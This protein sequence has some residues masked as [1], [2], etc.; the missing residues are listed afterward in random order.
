MLHRGEYLAKRIRNLS[1]GGYLPVEV[2][3]VDIY[4]KGIHW[5]IGL[6]GADLHVNS[7]A[8]RAELGTVEPEVFCSPHE[9][10]ELWNGKC[11]LLEVANLEILEAR[12][13]DPTKNRF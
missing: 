4:G 1:H 13:G 5:H 12:G 8:V 6:R 9:L 2:P 10:H 3:G 7:L 11:E